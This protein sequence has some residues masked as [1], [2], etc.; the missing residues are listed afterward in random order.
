MGFDNRK[1]AK[2]YVPQEGDTLQTIAERETAAGNPLT[3]QEL[4]RYNWGTED[5]DEV[6]ACMRD[7]LGCRKRAADSRF[8]I[9]ADDRPSTPLLI[10]SRF[11][12]SGLAINN[13][14]TIW[15][16]KKRCQ[17]Q[18]LG[19]CALPSI[20][21]GFNSS[22]IR[23]NV[24]DHLGALEVLAKQYPDAKLMV[25]GH[26]DVVGDELYNKKLSERRAWSAYAFI[27]NDTDAWETLYN[28]DDEDWGVA[29]I[30]EIL[31]DLGY[32]PG[33]VDGDLGDKTKAAMRPS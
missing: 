21:F 6:E 10:P 18:F 8:V 27:A 32:D 29:V 4:A 7:Q 30:Q 26:T 13:V 11:G 12:Y 5:T 33:P 24:V 2:A 31:S 25:F 1:N 14:H 22:F 19:C 3:W 20:T 16:T 28:H 17:R 9:A 15:V 23:P